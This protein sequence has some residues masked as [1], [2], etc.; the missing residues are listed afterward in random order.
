M[1]QLARQKISAKECT[2]KYNFTDLPWGLCHCRTIAPTHAPTKCCHTAKVSGEVTLGRGEAKRTSALA[3]LYTVHTA[4]GGTARTP[5][6][7]SQQTLS[8]DHPSATIP[9]REPAGDLFLFPWFSTGKQS[10]RA[11]QRE[12]GHP[13]AW[14]GHGL[15]PLLG[16]GAFREDR[17]KSLSCQQQVLHRCPL[18]AGDREGQSSLA[19]PISS[20]V[21][22]K[23]CQG[24]AHEAPVCTRTWHEGDGPWPDPDTRGSMWETWPRDSLSRPLL[25]HLPVP[26]H[27]ASPHNAF[28]PQGDQKAS[29]PLITRFC[30]ERLPDYLTISCTH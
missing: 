16:L 15:H 14:E 13:G 4:T 26:H 23:Q 10:Y 19:V 5:Q 29:N 2:Y 12:A 30:V 7:T 8:T 11:G 25:Q 6:L 1:Y 18:S 3:W 28:A 27:E 22:S 21:P 9:L 17:S 24:H 20:C